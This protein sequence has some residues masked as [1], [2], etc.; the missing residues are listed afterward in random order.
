MSRRSILSFCMVPIL[1]G[2]SVP[3]PEAATVPDSLRVDGGAIAPAP[4]RADGVRVYK[5]IPYAAAP[6][7][8]RR[9]EPPAA[10]VPWQG[11]RSTDTFGADCMQAV[12]E[13]SPAERPR[14]E[15]CLFLNVWAPAKSGRHPVFVWIHG[16]GSRVGSGAQPTFDG[17]AFARKGIVVVTINYRLGPLGFLSTPELSARSGYDA[18]GNYG[19]MD[20]I[21]ALGWV[22]RNIGRFGGEPGRVTIG[23]ESSGS[24]TTSV[25]MASPLAKGLFAQAIGESGS[26]LRR[27]EPASMG[28]TT[29]AFEEKRGTALMQDLGASDLAALRRVPAER[30]L[31]S[32]ARLANGQFYNLPVVDGHLLP[33]APWRIFASGKFNDV[34]LLAGWNADEGSL[35]LLGPKR[36]FAQMLQA[37]YGAEAGAVAR[38]YPHAPGDDQ[39]ALVAAAGHHNIAYPTWLWAYAAAR[40]GRGPVYLYEFDH[41]PPVP[42]GTFGTGFDVRLA[43][44][45]HGAEIPYVFDT[46]EAQQGWRIAEADRAVARQMNAWWAAFISTGAPGGEGAAHWPRYVPGEAARRMQVTEHPGAVPDPDRARFDGLMKVHAAI[47]PPLPGPPAPRR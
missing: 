43:G 5:G 21:A 11:V 13:N 8:E 17:S 33:D 15:D 30:V 7:G 20:V 47:D 31:A 16:G 26:S 45:Y 40:F 23:G 29:L 27:A 18:S 37:T 4:A 34:P 9:W 28:A 42:E 44:A 19:F 41:A 22:R 3:S 1:V 14:S 10:V 12:N 25:M 35:T 38:L 39:A 6:I 32:A 24:V 36:S 2:I 46:L